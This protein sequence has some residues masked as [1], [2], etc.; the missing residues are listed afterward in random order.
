[1]QGCLQSRLNAFFI[2]YTWTFNIWDA[3]AKIPRRLTRVLGDMVFAQPSPNVPGALASEAVLI[4]VVG[5]STPKW[6]AY[7]EAVDKNYYDNSY[8]NSLHAADVLQTATAL[9]IG[10][11]KVAFLSQMTRTETFATLLGALVHD[12]RHPGVTNAY[13]TH[14]Q[15]EL[16]LRYNDASVLENFHASTAFSIASSSPE[17]DIWS[18][19]PTDVFQSI[20]GIVISTVLATDL[21]RHFTDLARFKSRTV[22][23]DFLIGQQGDDCDE[24]RQIF[25]DMVVHS[26]DMATP[27]KSLDVYLRWAERVL[28]E[29]F[30]QG[31]MEKEKGYPVSQFMDRNTTNIAK[32]QVGFIG[33]LV[34]P[35][36]DAMEQNFKSIDSM[37]K[38]NL[39]RNK[40]FWQ[41]RVD[42]MEREMV[43]GTQVMPTATSS[44]TEGPHD[45]LEAGT[46]SGLTCDKKLSASRKF[47]EYN[48][49]DL[50]YKLFIDAASDDL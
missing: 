13:L 2:T 21:T 22:A 25:M 27:T 6:Q 32:C 9:S 35:L 18:E 48:L 19:M 11:G 30:C 7:V 45:D 39:T 14:S 4:D 28:T 49:S 47:V 37:S 26:S 33:M 20:R 38:Q 23:K 44:P 43:A 5:I 46:R 8:H 24:D 31:D 12:V 50:A 16:A 34:E 42:L 1:M 41:E 3:K 10:E 17:C 15:H 36:F 29:F 40:E